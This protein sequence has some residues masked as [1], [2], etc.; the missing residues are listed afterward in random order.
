MNILI[1]GNYFNNYINW[2]NLKSLIYVKFGSNYNL[3]LDNL[4][5][6]IEELTLGRNFTHPIVKLPTNLIKLNLLTSYKKPI[7]L[8]PNITLEII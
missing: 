1:L 5:E 2:T 4:P 3:L 7:N 6:Q 8:S